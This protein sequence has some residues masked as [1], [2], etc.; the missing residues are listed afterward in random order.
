MKLIFL[1]IYLGLLPSLNASNIMNLDL[2]I[3]GKT[4]PPIRPSKQTED[5]SCS[6][7][8]LR[9]VIEQKPEV[10]FIVPVEFIKQ[11]NNDQR[12]HTAVKRMMD[13]RYF[14]VFQLYGTQ[15]YFGVFEHSLLG[16]KPFRDSIIHASKAYNFTL[17]KYLQAFPESPLEAEYV[18]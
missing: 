14:Y 7:E 12:F 11:I 8:Q 13:N 17:P 1:L 9:A 15:Q 3:E 10:I 16:K 6:H 5:S 18:D 2:I 4:H